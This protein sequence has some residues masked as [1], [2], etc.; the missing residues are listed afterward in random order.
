MM[1]TFSLFNI[2]ILSNYEG[3]N[4]M[5]R[6]RSAESEWSSSGIEEK[7]KAAGGWC[8]REGQ[9]TVAMG[10]IDKKDKAPGG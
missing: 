8:W 9:G 3:D 2:L 5:K 7:D 4:F 1:N 10:H 6:Y